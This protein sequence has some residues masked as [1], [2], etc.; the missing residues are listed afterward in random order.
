MATMIRSL[1]NWLSIIKRRRYNGKRK[2]TYQKQFRELLT[3]VYAKQAYFGDFF[4]GGLQTLD[5]VT[6]NETAFSLKTTDIPLV[7]KAGDVTDETA[8]YNR[9]ANVAFG[10]G[11]GRTHLFDCKA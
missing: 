8:T 6:E 9:D 4:G 5:G 3:A 10:T 2:C 7:V 1:R 11:C